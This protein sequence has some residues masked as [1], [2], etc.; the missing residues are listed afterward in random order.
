MLIQELLDNDILQ[1]SRARAVGLPPAILRA[2]ERQGL[3]VPV[4]RGAW[5]TPPP[6]ETQYE[7]LRR[8]HRLRTIALIQ[9]MSPRVAA[10]HISAV[11]L[12]G[13]PLW[14]TP[15]DRVHLVRVDD[16]QSRA[17]LGLT[18]HQAGPETI[19]QQSGVPCVSVADA[20]VGLGQV[21]ARRA[22]LDFLIAGDEALRD[23]LTTLDEI[24]GAIEAR[25]GGRGLAAVRSHRPLLDAR[26]ES[27]AET[28]FAH[29]ARLLG[30]VVTPQVVI[31]AEGKRYRVDFMLKDEPI[32]IEVDGLAKYGVS[33][34]DVHKNLLLEKV[35]EDALRR[36]GYIVV[37]ILWSDL[38]SPKIVRKKVAAARAQYRPSVWLR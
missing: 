18:V 31:P 34:D 19:S 37:R 24:D 11:V 35:R 32:I 26:H 10:S 7:A 21:M 2:W 29:T 9:Q 23:G 17:R 22:P 6:K 3:L 4:S 27:V 12:H 5:T 36:A 8:E 15:L 38:A 30:L 14:S 20:L 33:P 25:S 1:S 16:N 13:L 28:R